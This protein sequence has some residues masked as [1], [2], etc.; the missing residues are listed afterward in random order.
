M[1]KSHARD[2]KQPA[3]QDQPPAP[4]LLGWGACYFVFSISG[5]K[6]ISIPLLSRE[7]IEET[8]LSLPSSEILPQE[9]KWLFWWLR[10]GKRAVSNWTLHSC[11]PWLLFPNHLSVGWIGSLCP[12]CPPP[13][14][15]IKHREAFHEVQ[16]EKGMRVKSQFLPLP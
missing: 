13:L 12:A 10:F 5:G 15:W 1:N 14:L 16:G 8:L 11:L 6:V 7:H 9:V 3:G 2:S 4:G